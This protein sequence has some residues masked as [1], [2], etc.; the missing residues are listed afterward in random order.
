MIYRICVEFDVDAYSA[1]KAYEQAKKVAELLNK[2]HP[3]RR[4]MVKK[5]VKK[6][7]T[8]EELVWSK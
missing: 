3:D 1:D 7:Y 4:A 6:Y 8:D 5:A 2:Q